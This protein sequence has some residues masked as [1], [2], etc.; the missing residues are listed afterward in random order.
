MRDRR[1]SV[2]NRGAALFMRRDEERVF[3]SF[4]DELSR[5]YRKKSVERA[6][7][8]RKATGVVCRTTRVNDSVT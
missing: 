1:I 5:S 8:R 7:L 6:I 3:A 2:L 4:I